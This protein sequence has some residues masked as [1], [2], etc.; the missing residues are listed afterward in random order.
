MLT[1]AELVDAATRLVQPRI[2]SLGDVAGRL[3]DLEAL[4][5]FALA[6]EESC[7]AEGTPATLNGL[8]LAL[9]A[10]PPKRPRSLRP[11]AVHVTTWH[12]AKGLEWP[13]VVLTGLEYAPKPRLFE[14][15]AEADGA[16]DLADPLKGRWIRFWPWPYGAQKKNVDLDERAAGSVLGRAAERKAR[17]EETRLL[18][19]GVTRA[20]DY[21][22]FAPPARGE[23]WLAVLD[24]GA[25]EGHVRLPKAAGESVKAGEELFAAETLAL[26]AKEAAPLAGPTATFVAVP[27]AAIDRPPL[28]RTPSGEETEGAFEVV[29]RIGL[30]PRLPLTGDPDMG[31]VGNALH[32]VFAAD[33][34]GEERTDRLQRAA[35]TLSRWK[36]SEVQAADAIAAADRLEAEIRRRWPSCAIL[37]EVPVSARIDGRLVTGRIDLLVAHAGRHIVIDHKSFPGSKAEQDRRAAGHGAQLAL[38]A[39][40]IEAATGEPCRDLFIHMPVAGALLRVAPAEAARM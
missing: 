26:A 34:G 18:Y 29:E 14:P 31:A 16:V 17:E 21:L 33:D 8:M 39:S 23:A 12:R 24:A 32:A 28:R 22:V 38:Y 10:N 36:I 3:D 6:Y 27:R 5:G 7:G 40:A 4:R 9:A 25:S 35:A 2:E 19:V 1:P 37:R 15:V 20:R 13:L 11:D 30:G